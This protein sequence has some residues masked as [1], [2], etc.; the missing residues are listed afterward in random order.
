MLETFLEN[1]DLI[2]ENIGKGFIAGFAVGSVS[3]ALVGFTKRYDD[4]PL[5][6]LNSALNNAESYGSSFGYRASLCAGLYTTARCLTKDMDPVYRDMI[7]FG[8]TGALLGSFHGA[9]PCLIGGVVG[10]GIGFLKSRLQVDNTRI[11]K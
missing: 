1:S 6:A 3:G 11:R 10:T 8:T 4:L 7:S 9:K 5:I 2:S